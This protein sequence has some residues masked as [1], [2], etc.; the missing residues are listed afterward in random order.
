MNRRKNWRGSLVDYNKE[1]FEA[2]IAHGVSLYENYRWIPELTFPMVHD[3]VLELGVKK[4]D[5]ILDFGCAKGYIVWAFRMFGYQSFGVDISDYAIESSPREVRRFVSL[6]Q[7]LPRIEFDICIA[8]DVLEHIEYDS[9]DLTISW[10]M[11]RSDKLFVVV[12]LGN[13]LIYEIPA[14]EQDKTHIIRE[15][16]S[17]WRERFTRLGYEVKYC[18]HSMGS[19]KNKWVEQYPTGNGFFIV[20]RIKDNA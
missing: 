17:W 13:G 14:M 8:K 2:G 19:I 1:Y 11:N 12:P 4:G 20:E 10:I 9:L 18:D 5:R 7:D 3:L 16:L 15:S 6:P